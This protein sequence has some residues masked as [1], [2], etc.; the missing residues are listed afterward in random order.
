MINDELGIAELA[1]Y[2]GI[3]SQSIYVRLRDEKNKIQK[4]VV[5]NSSPIRI[6]KE[7]L[8]DVFGKPLEIKE[9]NTIQHTIQQENK[10]DNLHELELLKNKISFLEQRLQDKDQLII[11]KEKQITDKDD[12]IS[13]QQ[14]EIENLMT[15]LGQE[16]A[17]HLQMKKQIDE[18]EI[19]ALPTAEDNKKGWNIFGMFKKKVKE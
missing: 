8:P 10:S 5:P 14:N 2:A 11:E 19:K 13:K 15:L 9:N 17:L 6:R 12:Y 4:Y 16:Q 3:Q 7:A 18:L 1:R